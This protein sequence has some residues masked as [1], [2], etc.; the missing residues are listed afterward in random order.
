MELFAPHGADG[1]GA[2]GGHNFAFNTNQHGVILHVRLC[3]L[4]PRADRLTSRRPQLKWQTLEKCCIS[5]VLL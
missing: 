5:R 1:K 2:V 3:L 4:S